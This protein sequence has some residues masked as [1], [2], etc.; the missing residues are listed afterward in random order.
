MNI[1]LFR[2]TRTTR[3]STFR[4][5]QYGLYL[6]F[7]ERGNLAA[8]VSYQWPSWVQRKINGEDTDR[9]L[10]PGLSVFSWG[11]DVLDTAE[12]LY[13]TRY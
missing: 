4:A 7:W 9:H 1:V 11:P 3:Q 5:D 12:Y 8:G 13:E 2:E 10:N 6:L